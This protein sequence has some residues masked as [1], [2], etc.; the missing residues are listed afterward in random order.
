MKAMVLSRTVMWELRRCSFANFQYRSQVPEKSW[1]VSLSVGSAG[2]I[3][4]S[5]KVNWPTQH[6]RSFPGTKPLGS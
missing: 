5:L 6:S 3:F 2:Q 1:F 4:M